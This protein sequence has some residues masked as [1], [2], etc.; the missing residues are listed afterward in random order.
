MKAVLR[1]H[2]T[3]AAHIC[4]IASISMTRDQTHLILATNE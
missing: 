4:C 3:F 2:N 1:L